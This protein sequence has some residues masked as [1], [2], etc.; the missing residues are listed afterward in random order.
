MGTIAHM[1]HI[2]GLHKRIEE[3][4]KRVEV[5]ETAEVKLWEGQYERGTNDNN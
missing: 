1:I 4:E 5:L 2:E 3:L